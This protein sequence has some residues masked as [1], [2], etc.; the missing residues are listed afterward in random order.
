MGAKRSVLRLRAGVAV[1]FA[2]RIDR[3]A[4]LEELL[5]EKG[6]LTEPEIEAKTSEVR[7]RTT[8]VPGCPKGAV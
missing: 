3:T 5:I 4:A 7:R 2:E 6:I 1:D 8:R